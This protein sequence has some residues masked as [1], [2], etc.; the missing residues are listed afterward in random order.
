MSPLPAQDSA[1]G[2]TPNAAQGRP[3]RWF[4]RIQARIVALFLILLLLVQ[5]LSFLLIERGVDANATAAISEQLQ[6]GERVFDTVLTQRADRFAEATRLLASDYGFRSAISSDDRETIASALENH[7]ERIGAQVAFLTDAQYVLRAATRP[8]AVRYSKLL[9]P[10]QLQSPG[11][12]AHPVFILD[13]QPFLLVQAAIKAPL[14]VGWV[15]MAFPVDRELLEAAHKVLSLD[16]ALVRHSDGGNWE[17]LEA[18]GSLADRRAELAA[19]LQRAPRAAHAVMNLKMGDDHYSGR[20][21]PLARDGEQRIDVVLVRS[22]TEALAPYRQLKITLLLLTIA[23]V[24]VFAAGSVLTARRIANPIQTLSSAASALAQGDYATPIAA[25]GRDEIGGL[26]VALENMRLAVRAR[27]ESIVRLAYWD[28]LTD[29]PNRLQFSQRTEV[30]IRAGAAADRPF[31]VLMLD[32]D[33][34]K[35]V[36]DVL[37]TAFGDRVLKRVAQRLSSE[38]LDEGDVLARLGGDEFAV[39]APGADEAGAHAKARRIQRAFELAFT[40]DAQAVDLGAGIG[41]A[42]YPADG[43]S[44][45]DLLTHSEMAMY[46][47]K[48]RKGGAVRYDSS[49]DTSSEAS[50]SL[51]TQ[52]RQAVAGN[53]LRLY[54]QAK[55]QVRDAA[56][57]GAEALVRWQHPQRGLL[58]PSAFI[59]FAEQTGFIRDITAWML[60]NGVAWLAR[61]DVR[62]LHWRLSVNLSTRDLLDQDLCA[63]LAALLQRHGVDPGLLCLEITESAIM[64]DPQRSQ[65]TLRQLHALGVKLSIDDFGT[66]YS[67]LAYLQ[68]LQVDE[69][70][71]DRSFVG[72]MESDAGNAVIVRSTI[73]LGHNLGL[74]VVAEGVETDRAWRMLEQ[75]GCDEAQGY[76][77]G[78]PAPAEEMTRTHLRAPAVPATDRQAATNAV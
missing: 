52:L 2:G 16:A 76:L 56:I 28:P 49:V 38:C 77:I 40:L 15:A 24:L 8:D 53:E 22:V 46:A 69:L 63:R 1:V 73:E 62:A 39:L 78:K 68:T 67:S 18:T 64:D 71:I 51:M 10:A 32:L 60:D 4:Q 55:A 31:A 11:G 29:L 37:G 19:E 44:V 41:I 25:K 5:A 30:A 12:A 72:S 70:K 43:R 26:A 21:V 59:P 7:G 9:A 57:V 33:R 35:H 61:E 3:A 50:L 27:E 36:N 6:V 45:S 34:F 13:G 65:A 47:A 14:V 58:P 66:G 20:L 74:V 75:L 17:V 54:L 23:G 42:L 48:R